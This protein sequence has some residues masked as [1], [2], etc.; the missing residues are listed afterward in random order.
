MEPP[1]S[2]C[3]RWGRRPGVRSRCFLCWTL[4]R[5]L[6]RASMSSWTTSSCPPHDHDRL[7]CMAWLAGDLHRAIIEGEISS[8][9]SGCM[10]SR[11]RPSPSRCKVSTHLQPQVLSE[12][13]PRLQSK[14]ARVLRVTSNL[15][16]L[17]VQA[18]VRPPFHFVAQVTYVLHIPYT[19]H[20]CI[21]HHLSSC[22]H[23]HVYR[24]VE[25]PEAGGSNEPRKVMPV[26]GQ[27]SRVQGCLHRKGVREVEV[28]SPDPP[29]A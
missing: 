15:I 22:L 3:A 21:V 1:A 28:K 19:P 26:K 7:S 24:G 16:V 5:V 14:G 27:G 10:A 13:G 17:T 11:A 4:A 29:S 20:Q 9:E 25:Q 23:M 8:R 6:L 2:R 18:T 12:S